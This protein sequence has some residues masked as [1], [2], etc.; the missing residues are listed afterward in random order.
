M[1]FGFLPTAGP[2][3]RLIEE[4]NK[5]PGI[6]PKSA[7]RLAYH[8]LRIPPEEALGLA[9]AITQVKE[10]IRLCS[11]CFN[12]TDSE[13]CNICQDEDRDHSQICVVEQPS[14]ILA[15]ERTRKYRGVYHALH[16][17]I[18]P[19]EG[20]GPEELRISEFMQRVNS[21]AVNEVILAINPNLE[22]ETTIMYLCELLAPL[23]IQVTRL[24]RGLPFGSELEYA[25]DIT[26]SRAFEERQEIRK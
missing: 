15:L 7:Q 2:V 4:L 21:G 14:D 1:N 11:T 17:V 20:V 24:A 25:D 22:G 8:L 26:L 3:A 13:P 23:G 12:I 9:E 19:S 6:G 5:L 16:G 18:S 10:K